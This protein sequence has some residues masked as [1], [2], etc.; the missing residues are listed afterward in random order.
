MKRHVVL[1]IAMLA[2]VVIAGLSILLATRQPVAATPV[3]SALVGQS[4]PPISG[5]PFGGGTF[6]LSAE[7]GKIVVV[8]FF[9]SWC[10]PCQVEEP[11]LLTF[12]WQQ[13]HRGVAVVGVVF[14]DTL[15][16]AQ[17]FDT[18][19]GTRQFYPSL[20]DPNGTFAFHYGVT[21]PPSTFVIDTHGRVVAELLG[22]VT[23]AQLNNVIARV[24]A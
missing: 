2:L 9:A 12:A 14:N 18:K 10:G 15:A 3:P 6:S 20:A 16:A 13:R 23:T 11:N 22:P 24:R 8:N 7:R 17:A 21:S 1:L 5:T 19:W 4:A